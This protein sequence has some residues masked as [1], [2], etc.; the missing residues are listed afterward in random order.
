M[1]NLISSNSAVCLEHGAYLD[2]ENEGCPTCNREVRIAPMDES[3]SAR[4][5]QVGGDHYGP[6]NKVQAIDLALDQNLGFCEASAIKYLVRWRK[7]GGVQDLEKAIHYINMLIEHEQ[8]KDTPN[9]AIQSD[10]TDT[11]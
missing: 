10:C 2:L 7:K 9:E 4:N 1:G 6:G 11:A 8:K 5:T 3:V